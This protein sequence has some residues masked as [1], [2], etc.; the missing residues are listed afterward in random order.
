MHA[1]LENT[2]VT[3]HF[4]ATHKPV[5]LANT[6]TKWVSNFLNRVCDSFAV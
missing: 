3:R 1:Y 2:A 5:K 6:M 4:L